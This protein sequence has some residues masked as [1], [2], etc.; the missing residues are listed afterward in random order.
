MVYACYVRPPG[1]FEAGPSTL[2]VTRLCTTCGGWWSRWTRFVLYGLSSG[3]L[4]L[5][6]EPELQHF[7]VTTPRVDYYY[8]IT[9]GGRGERNGVRFLK[10]GFVLAAAPLLPSVWISFCFCFSVA[11]LY[12]RIFR[13]PLPPLLGTGRGWWAGVGPHMLVWTC[14]AVLYGLGRDPYRLFFHVRFS[15]PRGRATDRRMGMDMAEGPGWVSTLAHGHVWLDTTHSV[16]FWYHRPLLSA[17]LPSLALLM[18]ARVSSERRVVGSASE[19]N[20]LLGATPTYHFRVP[21]VKRPL[22]GGPR[23]FPRS[24]GLWQGDERLGLVCSQVRVRGRTWWAP[25]RSGR[26]WGEVFSLVS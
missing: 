25:R 15:V 4:S 24:C 20:P 7:F 2:V 16:A 22:R 13:L 10:L 14:G 17:S 18:W 8:R 12:G 19:A 11:A 26:P 6:S 1:R 9:S 23:R 3:R 5:Q 21:R